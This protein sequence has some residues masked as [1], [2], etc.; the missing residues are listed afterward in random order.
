[1]QQEA[2][3]KL[4]LAEGDLP[5]GITGLFSPCGK[6]DFCPGCGQD[7]VVGDG[8]PVGVAPQI[9]DGIA[10]TM[11]GFFDV[12]APVLFIKPVFERFLGGRI[13]QGF[14]GGREKKFPLP[15]QGIQKGEVFPFELIPENPDRDKK[16]TRSLPDPVVRSES[17]AGDDT[18]HVD[19]VIQFL[20]P[21]VEDLDD[22]G[23]C[24]EKFSVS[25]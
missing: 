1:M 23:L 18:M 9:L 2:A 21:G 17:G 4:F 8:D 12:R 19:M 10:E 11:K 5:F 24:A 20:V 7:P 6:G 13:A 16:L 14:A 25:R 22:A 3:D 15:V